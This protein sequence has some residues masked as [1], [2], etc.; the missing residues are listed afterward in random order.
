MARRRKIERNIYQRPDGRLELGYRDSEGRQRWQTMKQP[1]LKA[2]RA[3]LHKTLAK[4][5]RG[6]RVVPSPK[7]R[8]GEA[9]EGWLAGPVAERR[10]TTQAAYKYALEHALK[11]WRRRRLDSIGPNTCVQLVRE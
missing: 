8:F 6:E 10:V 5:A 4:R 2:A 3:E 7:L 1:G 11:R 9:A